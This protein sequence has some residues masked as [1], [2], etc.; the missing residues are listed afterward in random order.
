MNTSSRIAMIACFT[1][2]CALFLHLTFGVSIATASELEDDS[3]GLHYTLSVH[4]HNGNVTGVGEY[5]AGSEVVVEAISDLGYGFAKWTD[6]TG[7][8]VSTNN[9]YYF[10]MPEKDVTLVAH[11]TA[12]YQLDE[13][14]NPMGN[15]ASNAAILP[16]NPSV[17]LGSTIQFT[18]LIRKIG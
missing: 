10:I 9:P 13:S 11:F 5:A 7:V 12:T 18:V 6:L 17:A 8:E 15:S 16:C 1:I 3:E 2:I 14:I 4:S